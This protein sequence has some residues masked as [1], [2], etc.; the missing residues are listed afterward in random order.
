M[1]LIINMGCKKARSF[2]NF[3]CLCL[4]E[5]VVLLLVLLMII[6]MMMM[7]IVTVQV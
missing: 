7:I 1:N 2:G 4:K 3:I 6:S 5:T